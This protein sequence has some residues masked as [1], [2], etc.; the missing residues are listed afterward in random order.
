MLGL[1]CPR[2]GRPTPVPLSAPDEMRCVACGHA[3]PTPEPAR[4]RLREARAA[5]D[6]LDARQRQ[7]SGA[8]RLAF[9]A[10]YGRVLL[11]FWLV[12]FACGAFEGLAVGASIANHG[13]DDWIEIAGPLCGFA[14]CLLT[15][16]VVLGLLRW[17]R[18]SFEATYAANPPATEGGEATCHVCGA[19]LPPASASAIAMVRC[20]FCQADNLIDREV[21]RR[22]ARSRRLVV[23]DH[24]REVVRRARRFGTAATVAGL[25][26]L[27]ILPPAAL[28]AH[29]GLRRLVYAIDHATTEEPPP[30]PLRYLLI[31][32]QAC[33][34]ESDG[35]GQVRGVASG[36]QWKPHPGADRAA[37]FEARRLL[38]K[39]VYVQ[40][41]KII[42]PSVMAVYHRPGTNENWARVR[43]RSGDEVR[44]PVTALCLTVPP[45]DMKSLR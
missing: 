15:G 25:S 33:V 3:G 29:F 16:L 39:L 44:A 21:M 36:G 26:L 9:D 8:Q 41:R 19:P 27:W 30:L 24:A 45:S 7:I 5:L 37:T 43:N 1:L 2:C 31:G 32:D 11:S 28:G 42:G 14:A 12:L 10:H 40:G 4:S 23:E 17:G 18:Q 6:Q 13:F 22:I 35:R 20:R 34:H 38:D